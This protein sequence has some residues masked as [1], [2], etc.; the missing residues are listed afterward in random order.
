MGPLIAAAMFDEIKAFQ[1]ADRIVEQAEGGMLGIGAGRKLYDYK[2]GATAWLGERE[3]RKY[4]AIARSIVGAEPCGAAGRAFHA[5]WIRFLSSTAPEDARDVAR[6]LSRRCGGLALPAALALKTQ[7]GG[8]TDVLKDPQV[9]RT[10]AARDMWQLIDRIA[11]V[12]LGG[13]RNSARARQLAKSGMTITAWLADNAER[14][15]RD[16]GPQIHVGDLVDTCAQWLADSG[17]R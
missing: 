8:M 15:D 17:T 9:L 14:I 12:A 13:A 10:Y 3:R 16:D 2:R 5:L 4:S 6:A 1:V 11:A 7:I